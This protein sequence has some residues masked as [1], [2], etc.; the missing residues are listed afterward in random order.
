[1]SYDAWRRFA[2]I[3]AVE[4]DEK[5]RLRENREFDRI[6]ERARRATTDPAAV[7]KA[8]QS[9]APS[10]VTREWFIQCLEEFAEILGEESGKITREERRLIERYV[11]YELARERR[12]W[13]QEMSVEVSTE[14]GKML[15]VEREKWRQD[16]Y[17]AVA[18]ANKGDSVKGEVLPMIRRVTRDDAA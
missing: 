17:D 11:A 7:S 5:Q 1:M 12:K 14:L 6:T 2:Q 16:I 8:A 10:T 18:W 4:M 15:G 3:A 9:Y 13:R